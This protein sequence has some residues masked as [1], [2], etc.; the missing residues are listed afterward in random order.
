MGIFCFILLLLGYLGFRLRR[1]YH[2]SLN[3][4]QATTNAQSK[5]SFLA[6]IEL[7]NKFK[8]LV[9]LVQVIGGLWYSMGDELPS[10]FGVLAQYMSFLT[11]D[12]TKIFD[13]GCT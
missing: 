7:G 6:L 11:L 3:G 12:V 5:T 9:G 8:I 13:W 4:V 1:A 10:F 2:D